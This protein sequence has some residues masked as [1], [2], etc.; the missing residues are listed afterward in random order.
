MSKLLTLAQQNRREGKRFVKFLVVGGIGFVV[1]ATVFYIFTHPI[2][3]PVLV[4]QAISDLAA[5]VSNFTWN[6]YWTYPDS[7]SKSIRRQLTQFT[8][9]NTIGLAIRTLVIAAVL[10]P[11]GRLAEAQRVIPL[12]P[13]TIANYA[14]LATAVVVVLLWNFFVNR[15]WTYNDVS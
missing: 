15:F 12:A 2:H 9:V 7:R 8:A 10:G 3:L 1:D 14:S 5:I 4:A 11:Y 6:R 13:A